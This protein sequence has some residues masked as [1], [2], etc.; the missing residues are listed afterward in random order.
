M[1]LKK[2]K[3]F[4]ITLTVILCFANCSEHSGLTVIF[5]TEDG[6]PPIDCKCSIW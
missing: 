5:M 1:F 4:I 2:V 6:I 3:F